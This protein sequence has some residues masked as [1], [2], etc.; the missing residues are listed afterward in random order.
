MILDKEQLKSKNLKHMMIKGTTG[1][2]D[3]KYYSDSLAQVNTN[4][5]GY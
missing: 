1:Q 4:H 3:M 5:K 2:A